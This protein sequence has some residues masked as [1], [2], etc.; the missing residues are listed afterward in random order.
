LRSKIEPQ[1]VALS[2]KEVYKMSA[3]RALVDGEAGAS[4]FKARE[5]ECDDEG[6]VYQIFGGPMLGITGLG[7]IYTNKKSI[8]IGVGV[9]LDE[10]MKRQ[11]R[12]YDILDELKTHPSI[13]PIL[14]G[15]ELLE[16]SAHLIPEGGYK[17][18]PKLHAPGVL[19]AGDAGM[20]VNNV[21]WEGTNLAM[22]SGKIAGEVAASGDLKQYEKRL[23]KSFVMKDL[24]TYREVMSTIH[25]NPEIF[26][27][28]YPRKINEFFKMFTGVDGIPKR[29]K[30]HAFIKSLLRCVKDIPAMIKL[31]WSVLK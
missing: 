11:I 18:M 14:K 7:F 3:Q 2:V 5:N 22:I 31:G 12:P 15:G 19:V 25:N 1:D 21:H 16:Y 24:R 20:L 26:L 9:A 30:Y 8:S 23:K 6:T 10:L 28:F 13:A 29:T 27:G 17:K 4:P